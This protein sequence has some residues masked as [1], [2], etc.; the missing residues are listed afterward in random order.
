MN[1]IK[2]PHFGDLQLIDGKIAS[3]GNGRRRYDTG[4]IGI[5]EFR[6][7][8]TGYNVGHFADDIF[9]LFI[10]FNFIDLHPQHGGGNGA[11][12]HI[13]DMDAQKPDHLTRKVDRTH[14]AVF[15]QII[16]HR[17]VDDLDIHREHCLENFGNRFGK[18]LA[19]IYFIQFV[20]RNIVCLLME[21]DHIILDLVIIINRMPI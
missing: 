21:I 20:H 6:F 9:D 1:K 2:T 13:T 16:S 18:R 7:Q 17:I 4:K 15:V 19:D 8:I 12:K 11:G 5:D 14:H 3:G 10:V